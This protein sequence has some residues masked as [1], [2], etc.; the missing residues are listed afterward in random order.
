M[1]HRVVVYSKEGCHLC[2]R[3]ISTL[4]ELSGQ[5]TFQLQILDIAKDEKLFEKF[6][7]E[8]PVVEVDGKVVFRA[9]DI[10]AL[11]DI[12]RKITGIILELNN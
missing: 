1:L 3:A 5:K 9:S 6:S 7:V 2:E 4:S 11:S 10:S 12:E 8:I